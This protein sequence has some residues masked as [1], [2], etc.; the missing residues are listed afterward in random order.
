[1]RRPAHLLSIPWLPWL[2]VVALGCA[3]SN[4][5]FNP[6]GMGRDAGSDA[7]APAE[8]RPADAWQVDGDRLPD[9]PVPDVQ[10]PPD[11]RPV[12]DGPPAA[13]TAADRAPDTPTPADASVDSNGVELQRGLVGHWPME[14]GQST[15][16]EDRS[17]RANHGTLTGVVWARP[18]A[19]L[20][21]L[22][23]ACLE[24]NGS[25]W[26]QAPAR[27]LPALGTAMTVSL[28]MRPKLSGTRTIFTL[29]REGSGSNPNVGLQ[30][31]TKGTQ[32]G[33]WLYGG[34]NM[35]VLSQALT[36]D[37]WY[38]VAYTFDGTTHRLFVNAAAVN[39]SG[40]PAPTGAPNIVRFGSYGSMFSQLYSGRLDDVRLYDRVLTAAE[41]TALAKP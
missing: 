6:G 38:H 34:A 29:L 27:G 31:G 32:A 4:P 9:G 41:I 14:E 8:V 7:G 10:S 19:P 13:D 5:E 21:A 16:F 18:G 25:S 40:E 30:I 15:G 11:E 28:W 22:G 24:F 23:T 1:M 36:A 20:P 33:F 2:A 37:V 26:A 12:L 3:Q 39:S 35:E 17:G